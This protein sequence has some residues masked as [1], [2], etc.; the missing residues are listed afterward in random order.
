MLTWPVCMYVHVFKN[1]LYIRMPLLSYEMEIIASQL[2]DRWFESN[3][4]LCR[5]LSRVA[6][7]HLTK[8][9]PPPRVTLVPLCEDPL[10]APPF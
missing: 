7:A 5:V 4:D 9:Y 2:S 10:L 3:Y 6:L 8:F 1:L